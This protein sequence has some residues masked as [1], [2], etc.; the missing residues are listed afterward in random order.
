MAIRLSDIFRVK[1]V[2][3]DV[4]GGV[5]WRSISAD[6]VATPGN[7]Y[8][9]DTT[10][11]PVTLTLPAELTVKDAIGIKDLEGTFSTNNLTIARNGH[12]I[13]GLAENFIGNV[14]GISIEFSYADVDNGMTIVG[15][16]W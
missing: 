16:A 14:N 7:G 15:G 12:N 8:I 3:F 11:G 4:V 5:I 6:T 2:G 1:D 13:Q 10:D 9:V